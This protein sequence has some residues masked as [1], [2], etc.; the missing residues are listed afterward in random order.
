MI[1]RPF[2]SDLWILSRLVN[3]GRYHCCIT[4]KSFQV[5]D[6]PSCGM[7]VGVLEKEL[8]RASSSQ[9]PSSSCPSQSLPSS[10]ILSTFFP[11]GLVLDMIVFMIAQLW[12]SCLV[13]LQSSEWFILVLLLHFI[14]LQDRVV[15]GPPLVVSSSC[16]SIVVDVYLCSA[17]FFAFTCLSAC[18]DGAKFTCC[19]SRMFILFF[20]WIAIC[21]SALCHWFMPFP[22]SQDAAWLAN[23]VERM[24]EKRP[25]LLSGD[26]N[27][28]VT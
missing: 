27:D 6:A 17:W 28:R 23:K 20:K 25:C 14:W 21:V 7:G 11:A 13:M 18:I 10:T 4:P 1:W 16:I 15:S 3:F 12:L 26:N 8:L 22:E 9:L 19:L 5:M 24:R 2:Q